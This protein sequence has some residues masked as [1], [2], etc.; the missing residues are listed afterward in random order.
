MAIDC[1]QI[2]NS[3][4]TL[5]AQRVDF[6]ISINRNLS[7]AIAKKSEIMNFGRAL[8]ED[9]P[10]VYS[11][12]H[13]LEKTV[14]NRFSYAYDIKILNDGSVAF[15]QGNSLWRLSGD[16]SKPKPILTKESKILLGLTALAVDEKGSV[17]AAGI[18]T[19]TQ[20]PVLVIAFTD[21]SGER[22]VDIPRRVEGIH[23]SKDFIYLQYDLGANAYYSLNR[24]SGRGEELHHN[25]NLREMAFSEKTNFALMESLDGIKK[26]AF[27][28]SETKDVRQ[29]KGPKI[30]FSDD[31]ESASCLGND[32]NI[33]LIPDLETMEPR[34]EDFSGIE[35]YFYRPNEVE[36]RPIGKNKVLIFGPCDNAFRLI[37]YDF[38]K[39]KF[40]YNVRREGRLIS[41][42]SKS[43]KVSFSYQTF[44]KEGGVEEHA[45]ETWEIGSKAFQVNK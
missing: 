41:L 45:I 1:Q 16:G 23:L 8:A 25:I 20:K 22:V 36:V 34:I 31:G 42:D 39:D 5:A 15:Q 10:N 24:K 7:K 11:N 19:Q 13:L 38:D 17:Y 29:Y 32:R 21:G 6:E 27:T 14:I 37:V 26:F 12:W 33:I 9:L 4:K 43:N 35:N 44:G 18:H 28:E 30:F 40:L 3:I 2:T